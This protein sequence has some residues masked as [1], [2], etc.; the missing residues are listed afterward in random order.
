MAA[1]NV[2][3]GNDPEH[4]RNRLRPDVMIVEM[5][6]EE[7]EQYTVCDMQ[8]A[9]TAQLSPHMPD[10]KP[11]KVWVAEAGYCSDTMYEDKLI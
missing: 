6:A 2:A 11:R 7:Y 8:H 5:S 10:G 3:S 9:T 1:Y 4:I